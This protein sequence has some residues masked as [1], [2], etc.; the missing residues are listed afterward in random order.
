MSTSAASL[1]PVEDFFRN[2][3]KTQFSISEDGKHIAWLAPHESRLNVFVENME[4]KEIT[5]ATGE[6]SRD[7]SGFLWGTTS[8]ILYIRDNGG[9]E[10]FLL[11][12]A[13]IDG[14]DAI[15]LTPFENVVVRIVDVL[16]EIENEILI[17]MNKRNPQVFDVYRLN[18]LTGDLTMVAE[19]P[20]NI[21]GW[22]TDHAGVVR[23]GLGS[24]G[25]N[26]T[27]LYRNNESEPFRELYTANFRETLSPISFTFDNKKLYVASNRGRNTTA[28]YLFNPETVMEEELIY[29]NDQ[30]DC[31]S[32]RLS[33]KRKTLVSVSFQG[34]KRERIIFDEYWKNIYTRLTELLPNTE[35]SVIDHNEDETKLIVVTYS[36][37]NSGTYYYYDTTTDALTLLSESRPWLNE[38]DMAEMQCVQ[39]TTR[40]G[41]TVHGY[42]SLPVGVEPKNLPVIM[43][44]HGGPWVRDNWGFDGRVQFLCNR[45]YAVLKMNYR[46]STGYGR[47]FWEA[48]FKQWGG[49]M[50]NDITDA[51]HWLVN[52]GVADP[53]RVA[54]LGGSYG[55]YAVLAGLAF[56][57]DVY[58][59]GVDIVGVSNLFTFR[60][61]IPEYWKPL[62]D[63]S[64]E[65]IGSV[66][67]DA[68]LLRAV[69]PVFH[70]DNIK[71]PLLVFQGAKDPRVNINESNQ[72]VEALRNKGIDVEYIVK[73]DEGHGFH[74]EEN[75]V[76]MYS[77]IESFL[78]KHLG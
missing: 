14:S 40:D 9:D 23:I 8:R 34:L 48:S 32:A 46:G 66:T 24:D 61:T 15:C 30:F 47:A 63:M 19:N 67:E 12:A 6:T 25:V 31:E 43:F 75:K 10:N 52:T 51:V 21:L 68:E 18:I 60:E 77:I 11:Y 59:C 36:D 58:C 50:Q 74:N 3:E 44:P 56:T 49:T 42:L 28:I 35:V 65:M 20:G 37:R 5:R 7:I 64:D 55:G 17:A 45:G 4:T 73:E 16:H 29:A 2:P 69:S 72:I 53:K 13:N 54:I 76:E 57:P 78:K 27:L 22:L 33:R 38:N 70:V 26:R 39:Y 1:I 71:V 41:L 62:N